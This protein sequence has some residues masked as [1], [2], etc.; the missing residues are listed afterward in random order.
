MPKVHHIGKQH[1]VQ[2]MRFPAKWGFKIAV[3]GYTQ[4]VV[5][6]FRKAEPWIIRLPFY[7]A[8]II[9]KWNGSQPDEESAI[10]NALRGRILDEEDFNKEKG[11]T[12]APYKDSEEGRE[13][14]DV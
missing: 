13:Y 8:I 2:Y 7:R 9:G 11:W 3:K 10:N 14:W 4:E 12:P 1:F 5:E 6:P